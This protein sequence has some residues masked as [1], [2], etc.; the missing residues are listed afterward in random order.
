M[1]EIGEEKRKSAECQGEETGSAGEE[2][3]GDRWM[4]VKR[5]QKFGKAWARISTGR[6]C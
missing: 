4:S 2:V 3:E 6:G 5:W 1:D